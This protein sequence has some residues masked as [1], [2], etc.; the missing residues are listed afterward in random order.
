MSTTKCVC[1]VMRIGKEAVLPP[2]RAERVS[3]APASAE[4]L[5]G[6]ERLG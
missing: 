5:G 1:A 6:P 2:A 4:F 3:R